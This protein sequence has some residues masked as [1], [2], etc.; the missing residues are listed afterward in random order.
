[1]IVPHTDS[2]R[3]TVLLPVKPFAL[4]KSRLAIWA[5]ASRAEWARAFYLD[6]LDA[7]F[8]TPLVQQVIV[9]TADSEAHVLAARAGAKVADDTPVYGLNAAVHRGA[10]HAASSPTGGPVAVLTADLPALRPEELMQ[11]LTDARHHPRAFLTDHTGSGT[12]ILTASTPRMLL[13]RFEGASRTQHAVTGAHELIIADVPGARLDVDT[14][15]DLGA[16]LSLG[17]GPYS[18]ALRSNMRELP[19]PGSPRAGEPP[20]RP[21]SPYRPGYPLCSPRSYFR[22]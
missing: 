6:T 15:M 19:T 4:G 14:P 7:I 9:V 1:M 2:T 16:A 3:W 20:W 5:G 13:P 18:T 22:K 17:V 12:T 11:V 10:T 21:P 8:H